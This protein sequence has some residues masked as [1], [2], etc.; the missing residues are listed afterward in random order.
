MT[1]GR[2]QNAR[3]RVFEPYVHHCE[4]IFDFDGPGKDSPPR[5]ESQEREKRNPGE[6][7]PL[8][9]GLFQPCPRFLMLD[10]VLIRRK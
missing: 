9:E 8:I 1:I 6:A 3:S 5:G 7:D 4:S 2:V 10:A